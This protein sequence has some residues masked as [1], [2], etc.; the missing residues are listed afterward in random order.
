LDLNSRLNSQYLGMM[1]G[2]SIAHHTVFG[3]RDK[4]AIRPRYGG[5]NRHLASL[6][7]SGCPLQ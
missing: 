7:G 4:A 2:S 1:E 3:E 5:S 6:G